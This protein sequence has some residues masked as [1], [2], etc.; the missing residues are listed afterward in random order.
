MIPGP[1]PPIQVDCRLDLDP[2]ARRIVLSI[3]PNS[4]KDE[5]ATA[6]AEI[7]DQVLTGRV[8]RPE[9]R[10][11]ALSLQEY[12]RRESEL[13]TWQNRM[14][15]WNRHVEEYGYGHWT[16]DDRRQFRTEVMNMAER[17][18]HAPWRDDLTMIGP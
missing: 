11:L 17:P 13:G 12:D 8:R 14:E 3:D 10:N 5:V 18:L 9:Q 16:F 1:P 7:K 4:S 6:Y 2:S 15:H